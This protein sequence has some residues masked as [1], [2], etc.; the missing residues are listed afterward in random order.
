MY[1]NN[2]NSDF[3]KIFNRLKEELIKVEQLYNI[4]LYYTVYKQ[5]Y[6]DIINFTVFDNNII[7][8]AFNTNKTKS[9]FI[10][11]TDFKFNEITKYENDF[12]KYITPFSL[13]NLIK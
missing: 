2:L 13:K 1:I 12:Y 8:S 6:K 11:T 10:L 9:W 3:I 5:F 4:F 7:L